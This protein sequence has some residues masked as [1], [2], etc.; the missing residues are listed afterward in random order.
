MATYNIL[1]TALTNRDATPKVLTD[2]AIDG[3]SP[4]VAYGFVQTK[5]AAD[6]VGSTYRM[7]QVPSGARVKSVVLQSDNL[8]SGCSVAIGVFYP[9]AIPLGAGLV[10]SQAS[11]WINTTFFASA[12]SCSGAVAPVNLITYSGSTNTI[13][14]QQAP[15]W[16]ALGLLSDPMINLDIVIEVA[17]AVATQGN[18]GLNVEYVY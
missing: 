16:S 5:G 2:A 13:A 3:G 10:S 12:Y 6:G 1:S 14:L 15:L 17:A 7:C 8:G 4:K 11:L 9:T 18:I